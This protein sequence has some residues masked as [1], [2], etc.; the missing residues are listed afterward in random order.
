MSNIRL[1]RRSVV[2]LIRHLRA[3][4]SDTLT[5]CVGPKE[6]PGST[7]A[8][9][10]I[11]CARWTS[12]QPSSLPSDLHKAA[13]SVKFPTRQGKELVRDSVVEEERGDSS[14]TQQKIV[15]SET[16]RLHKEQK[17]V[18]SNF[19]FPWERRQ[20]QG[21]ALSTWEQ[22]YWGVFVLAVAVFLFNRAGSGTTGADPEKEEEERRKKEEIQKLQAE[23]ARMIM[24]GGSVLVPGDEED[25]FE[26]LSP[27][28][29]M[30]FV[31]KTTGGSRDDPFAGM[32]PEEIDEYVRVHQVQ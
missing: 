12:S 14:N 24:V 9:R 19:M 16:A 17:D 25:P 4:L 10:L 3:G 23:R 8:Q 29:V 30:A 20:M 11:E 31:E 15:D 13:R 7:A 21:G 2:A 18:V 26:G 1:S 32:T 5:P 6:S 22:W 28:E 27:E